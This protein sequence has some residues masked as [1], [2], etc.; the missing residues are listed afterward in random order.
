MKQIYNMLLLAVISIMVASCN[1]NGWDSPYYVESIVGSW[2][3][4]YGC[5]GNYEYDIMGYDRVRYDFYANHTGRY[6]YYDSYWGL[7]YVDFDW[8]TYGDRLV[9][10]YYDGDSDYLFYGYDRNG[11]L[12]L[13]LDSR[14][15]QFTAYRPT[16]YWAPAKPLDKVSDKGVMDKSTENSSVSRAVKAKSE[17]T[18]S[19]AKEK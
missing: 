17:L 4:Y 9:I 15:Y 13:A 11:D 8:D 18:A 12:I 6:T 10:R 16:G 7:S 19:E 2:E 1:G 14:F 5:Q 3:S